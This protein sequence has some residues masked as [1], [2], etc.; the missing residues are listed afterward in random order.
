MKLYT[1]HNKTI[2]RLPDANGKIIAVR[3]NQRILLPEY[4]DKYVTTG[5]LS[6]V[7]S[8]NPAER[9]NNNKRQGSKNRLSE[10]LNH[11]QARN[12]PYIINS[13]KIAPPSPLKEPAEEIDNNRKNIVRKNNTPNIVRRKRIEPRV[14]KIKNNDGTRSNHKNK[15][16]GHLRQNPTDIKI[17]EQTDN[18]LSSLNI[19]NNIG[20]GILSYNRPDSLKRLIDSIIKYTDTNKTTIFISDDCSTDPE[21]LRY[22]DS[23]KQINKFCIIKNLE[24]IGIAGNSNRLIQCL[25]RFDYGILLNDDVEIKNIGWEYF[26]VDAMEKTGFSHLI[27]RQAGIYGA[28]VGSPIKHQNVDLLKNDEKPQGALLAFATNAIKT[29]GYMNEEYGQYGMEHVDW[30]TRFF[31]HNLNPLPGYYDV[32]GSSDF[33]ILHDEASKVE[34]RSEKLKHAKEKYALRT[35]DY[36]SPTERSK[37]DSISIIIPYR[38]INRAQSVVTVIENMRAQLFPR[39]NIYLSEHDE[40]SQVDTESITPAIHFHI[41]A[42]PGEPFNKSKAFNSGVDGCEDELVILHDADMLMPNYY[43]SEVFSTLK[44]ND[45]CHLG[46]DVS[47]YNETDTNRINKNKKAFKPEN[48]ERYVSYFEGGSLAC[49]KTYYSK[50]GGFYEAY[51][52][53]GCEDCDFY[54]RLSIGGI[55]KNDRRIPLYHLWHPRTNQWIDHHEANIKLESTLNKLNAKDRINDAK[56]KLIEKGYKTI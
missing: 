54:Y 51:S 52:G 26:Y 19:S 48:F 49:T 39:I 42:D 45:A 37:V 6:H 35:N 40:S 11:R 4:F 31:H 7:R 21:L 17:Y 15:Y 44:T 56:R 20:I 36:V 23:L 18:I 28:Q 9:L 14:N 22:L 32:N 10:N 29:I 13:D 33:F 25:E 46:K 50:I 30:S 16:H 24:N 2:M 47:Y 1:N 53:Y 38:D 55:F 5:H 27:F 8:I 3:P 43:V 12:Q 34:Q 41:I